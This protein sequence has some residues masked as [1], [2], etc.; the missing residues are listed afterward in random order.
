MREFSYIRPVCAALEEKTSGVAETVGLL[1]DSLVVSAADTEGGNCNACLTA[2][3]SPLAG[4]GE[5]NR[6]GRGGGGVCVSI[7]KVALGG[8]GNGPAIECNPERNIS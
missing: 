5:F 8:G 3:I 6:G 7:S 1:F 4:R 2:S